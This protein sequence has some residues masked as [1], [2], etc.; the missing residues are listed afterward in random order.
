MIT[1]PVK[2]KFE[3]YDINKVPTDY[4][5]WYIANGQKP[6]AV[7]LAKKALA[8]RATK[9]E[10]TTQTTGKPPGQSQEL[11]EYQAVHARALMLELAIQI[12]P[13]MPWSA[14]DQV[15][16]YVVFGEAPQ[17]SELLNEQTPWEQDTAPTQGDFESELANVG[18]SPEPAN[19]QKPKL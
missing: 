13:K 14:L 8:Y 1:W 9:G 4:L 7:E 2:G 3:N 6:D 11:T 17:L 16:K 12:N 5:N 18:K 19:V 10:T 15:R